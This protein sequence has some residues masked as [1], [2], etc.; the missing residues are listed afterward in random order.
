MYF[1]LSHSAYFLESGCLIGPET[2]YFQSRRLVSLLLGSMRLHPK[3]LGVHMYSQAQLYLWD[4][5]L[6]PIPHFDMQDL[7][8]LSHL[9]C[10][11]LALL[12]ELCSAILSLQ[13][14]K[15]L[16]RSG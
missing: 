7:C 8:P 10:L 6:P 13:N 12:E 1:H 3:V 14:F 2:F 11:N 9:P 4:W 5:D 16:W 15:A